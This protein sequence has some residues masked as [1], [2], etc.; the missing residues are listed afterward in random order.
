MSKGPEQPQ[1][2]VRKAEEALWRDGVAILDEQLRN[3]PLF[4]QEQASRRRGQ[5]AQMDTVAQA[6]AISQHYMS[7]ARL[8]Q[9]LHMS[10]EVYKNQQ[11][12]ELKAVIGEMMNEL[13][14]HHR[15]DFG[16][17]LD[18]KPQNPG[19]LPPPAG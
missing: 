19:N 16:I 8:A 3:A 15:V 12:E 5:L 1:D 10:C 17:V 9:Y 6:H 4:I 14:T 11:S 13:K 7:V 2:P 18:W